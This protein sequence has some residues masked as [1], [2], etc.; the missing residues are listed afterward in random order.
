MMNEFDE[1]ALAETIK[2]HGIGDVLLVL[3]PPMHQT[4]RE[5]RHADQTGRVGIVRSQLSRRGRDR[6]TCG[7]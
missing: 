7:V 3:G 4:R 5:D 2:R 6:R 1:A